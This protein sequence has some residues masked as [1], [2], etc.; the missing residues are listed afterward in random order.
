MVGQVGAAVVGG[1]QHEGFAWSRRRLPRMMVCT[2]AVHRAQVPRACAGRCDQA[3]VRVEHGAGKS[4]RSLIVDPFVFCGRTPFCSA[5]DIYRLLKISS[6]TGSATA[7]RRAPGARPCT[8]TPAWSR[9]QDS[10]PAVHGDGLG[11]AF[12]QQGRAIDRARALGPRAA[13]PRRRALPAAEKT[14]GSDRP[15]AAEPPLR[16]LVTG[17]RRRRPLPTP[18]RSPEAYP[19]QGS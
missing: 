14:A 8:V 4:S 19:R 16:A 18:V 3:S 2:E 10:L 11:L 6:I 17:A 15:G 13:T 5:I 9:G 12:D 7:T 1:V